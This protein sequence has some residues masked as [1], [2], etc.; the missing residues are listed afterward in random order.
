MND[1]ARVRVLESARNVTQDGDDP[2]NGKLTL[3]S[4]PRP[5]RL[6]LDIRHRE[7]RKPLGLAGGEHADDM[8]MLELRGERDLPLESLD[9]DAGDELTGQNLDHDLAAE[10]VFG[11]HEHARHSTSAQLPLD[12]VR[13]AERGLK[14]V[15]ERHR[16]PL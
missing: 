2:G 13:R 10:R 8:R 5:E 11:G 16:Q 1:A 4:D 3:P 14:L 7:E 9:A 12:G 6:A 15:S